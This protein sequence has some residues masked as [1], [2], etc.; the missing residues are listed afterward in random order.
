MIERGVYFIL[1]CVV[2]YVFIK[3]ARY[4][5][6]A[7]RDSN[8]FEFLT[9]SEAV[10]ELH[11]TKEELQTVEELITSIEICNPDE[12]EKYISCEWMTGA[13][14]KLKY[15][16]LVD[17]QNVVSGEMLKIAFSERERLRSLLCFQIQKINE[18]CNGNGNGNYEKINRRVDE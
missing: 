8:E 9:V 18:R 2:M 6:S 10:D 1:L 11:R 15:D 16:L 5:A 7:E 13:G 12:H 3:M 17:G 14:N 4:T